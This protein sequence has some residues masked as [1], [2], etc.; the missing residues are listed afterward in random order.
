[1]RAPIDNPCRVDARAQ[2]NHVRWRLVEG[3]LFGGYLHVFATHCANQTLQARALAGVRQIQVNQRRPWYKRE[4][5]ECLLAF[6]FYFIASAAFGDLQTNIVIGLIQVFEHPYIR[7]FHSRRLLLDLC[8]EYGLVASVH[9]NASDDEWML[10]N[11]MMMMTMMM[12]VIMVMV[13]MSDDGW[14]RWWF[15]MNDDD[16]R[17]WLMMSD[18]D[19][20]CC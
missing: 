15:I 1:M 6:N 5:S 13:M 18:D 3:H 9:L 17:W 4:A 2:G 7:G 11:I 20:W 19:W 8:R 10:T 12:M 16:R 14:W